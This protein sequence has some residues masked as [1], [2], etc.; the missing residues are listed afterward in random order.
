MKSSK[1]TGFLVGELVSAVDADRLKLG[2]MAPAA[3]VDLATLTAKAPEPFFVYV[4]AGRVGNSNS[5]VN[6][7]PRNWLPKTLERI[8]SALPL[9]G[10]RGHPDPE[11]FRKQRTWRDFVTVWV[12]GKIVDGALYL[13]GFIPAAEKDFQ[14]LIQ[15]TLAAGNPMQVSP[16]GMLLGRERDTTWDVEDLE[17][18]S[19]D[20]GQPGDAGF[21]DADVLKV[22]G[23]LTEETTMT[24]KE[25]L[26]LQEK[27]RQLGGELKTAQDALAAANAKVTTLE[28][29]VTQIGGELKTLKDAAAESGKA[30]VKAHRETLLGKLPETEREIGGELLTGDDVATLDKNFELVVSKLKKSR[31][32]L[33]IIGGETKEDAGTR[34]QGDAEKD[35]AG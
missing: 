1:V 15:L 27:N 12:A 29:T 32:G 2:D 7:K 30:A 23:E 11:Q 6:G 5:T 22:A 34:G 35:F 25:I 9:Y 18:I 21:S 33:R 17:P 10:Y 19:V 24:E 14:E 31:P 20:W 13:K 4:R 28:G 8:I 26:E 3:G 16:F